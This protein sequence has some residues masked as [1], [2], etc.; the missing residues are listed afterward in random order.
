M[1]AIVAR[2]DT[3]DGSGLP[4]SP[5]TK[6]EV[7][8]IVAQHQAGDPSSVE[9]FDRDEDGYLSWL[10]KHPSGFVLNATRALSAASMGRYHR[11]SCRTITSNLGRGKTYTAGARIKVCA[12][13][14]HSLKIWARY[15][16][17]SSYIDGCE[18]CNSYLR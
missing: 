10:A 3:S 17:K 13:D 14:L 2:K 11:T 9:T 18:V 4:T 6:S 7:D 12:P 16:A 8:E 1:G 15:N 5:L